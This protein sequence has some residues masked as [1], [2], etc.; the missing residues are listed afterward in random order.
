MDEDRI[1]NIAR[2]MCRAARLDPDQ[3]AEKSTSYT[4]MRQVPGTEKPEPAWTLF[5]LDA[6]R[7]CA[8][9]AELGGR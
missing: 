3:P 4:M 6:E 7:F 9:H 5:R 1:R 2:P 8:R